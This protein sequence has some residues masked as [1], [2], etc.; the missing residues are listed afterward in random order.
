M[1]RILDGVRPQKPDFATTRGYTED[2]W[3]MTTSCWAE[4][5]ISRPTVDHVLDA[6][7]SSEK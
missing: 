6:L 3:E 7:R 5:P 4:D 2:L 1:I